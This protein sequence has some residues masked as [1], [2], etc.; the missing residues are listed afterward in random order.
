MTNTLHRYGSEESFSDDFIVFAIPAR[1]FNDKNAVAAQRRFLEMACKHN[2][3]NIGDAS[4][5]ALFR[6][7]RKS[8]PTCSLAPLG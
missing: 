4:H 2:P 7:S 6:P 5:G 8:K 3:V 1:G